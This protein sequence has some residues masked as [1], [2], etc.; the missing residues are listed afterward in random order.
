MGSD[1]YVGDILRLKYS[2]RAPCD[3]L[4][5]A[6]SEE[7]NGVQ[8]CRVDT[9]YDDGQ[10]IRQVKEAVS[11]TKSFSNLAKEDSKTK[12]FLERLNARVEYKRKNGQITGT[13]KLK[14]DPRVETISEAMIIHK[15]TI[16]KSNY[17]VALVLYNGRNCLG[18][19]SS[20][21][22]FL[23]KRSA[24]ESK[25]FIFSLTVIVLNLVACILL[26]LGH[27]RVKVFTDATMLTDINK[28]GFLGF[29]SLFFSVMPLSVNILMRI[30][31]IISAFKL[32][33]KFRGY[34]DGIEFRGMTKRSLSAF[35]ETSTPTTTNRAPSSKLDS[36]NVLNP[37]VIDDLGDIDDAFF[38][39]T[40]TLTSAKAKYEV[41][42]IATTTK[43]YEAKD[44]PFL[45]TR[46]VMTEYYLEE[47][48]S[49]KGINS[50]VR[51]PTSSDTPPS[52]GLFKNKAGKES[53]K[54]AVTGSGLKVNQESSKYEYP[55]E[56]PEKLKL[57]LPGLSPHHSE[58]KRPGEHQQKNFNSAFKDLLQAEKKSPTK[59]S[60]PQSY[61]YTVQD[62]SSFYTDLLNSPE[63][64]DLLCLFS[65]C[66]KSKVANGK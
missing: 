28:A 60:K 33:R 54:S 4:I 49:S 38:D 42:T 19:S 52:H 9:M 65:V 46:E 5:L 61:S 13:F 37:S 3:M 43:L 41:K 24:I 7:L 57:T 26:T 20:H 34:S 23:S 11:L 30:F 8:A 53:D 44:E 29:V 66:H 25:I 22:V 1:I 14:A 6:T 47:M 2:E 45:V 12:K 31:H 16:I 15:G 27:N 21:L 62:N 32:Q 10:V 56:S 64:D 48:P 58:T 51:K 17:V 18:S 39:K 55:D 36:F 59:I 35:E 40:G 50:P 63:L